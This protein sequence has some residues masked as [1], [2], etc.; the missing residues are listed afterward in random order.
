[1]F[2]FG[3][4]IALLLG[5]AT[6]VL[7]VYSLRGKNRVFE[8]GA[9][10]LLTL[11]LS[12]V[13]IPTLL[14]CYVQENYGK[15]IDR[16]ER[17]RIEQLRDK[18][19]V[20]SEV[21]LRWKTGVATDTNQLNAISKV[22]RERLRRAD[23]AAIEVNGG[24]DRKSAFTS[25]R[26]D[27][28]GGYETSK[29]LE[30]MTEA[31]TPTLRLKPDPLYTSY[32]MVERYDEIIS[33]RSVHPGQQRIALSGYPE[34][35]EDYVRLPW[36][37][38]FVYV[39]NTFHIS[40]ADIYSAQRYQNNGIL[41]T[42]TPAGLLKMNEMASSLSQVQTQVAVIY[43][44]KIRGV[45]DPQIC[46]TDQF[47]VYDIPETPQQID[48][49]ADILSQPKGF[50]EVDSTEFKYRYPDI[51]DSSPF[52]LSL[53]RALA[54][55]TFNNL[56]LLVY[57]VLLLAVMLLLTYLHFKTRPNATDSSF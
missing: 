33:V 13:F 57:G 45:F 54:S 14:L 2:F 11:A 50:G 6:L 29:V 32:P 19:K 49:D 17:A 24:F 48:L 16:G 39:R 40:D 12:I 18:D 27:A 1:M 22:I 43:K 42:L 23:K 3:S 5:A 7:Q 38:G 35:P 51:P 34:A 41:L 15:W 46:V 21:V 9:K 30:V 25:L 26:S 52:P 8:R 4:L 55:D 31:V 37:D 53:Y 10:K 36:K 20:V 47:V 44:G 28:P 56:W